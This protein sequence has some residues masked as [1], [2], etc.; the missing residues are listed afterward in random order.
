MIQR[1][2]FSQPS[3]PQD[4]TKVPHYSRVPCHAL[5]EGSGQ[6]EG[7]LL[8]EASQPREGSLLPTARGLRA[9]VRLSAPQGRSSARPV[10]QAGLWKRRVPAFP[11]SWLSEG[12]AQLEGSACYPDCTRVRFCGFLAARETRK[13][14][15]PARQRGLQ[16]KGELRGL[17]VYRAVRGCLPSKGSMKGEY[18]ECSAR[19]TRQCQC[20]ASK[21][22][23]QGE[24]LEG[25][26]QA[27]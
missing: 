23:L 9:R 22:S 13:G 18:S 7:S 2:A 1:P 20:R 10:G 27:T 6:H 16:A 24:G 4:H 14:R 15:V 11:Q 8:H 26:A 5:C 3:G 12:S 19:A 21:G 17:R 25:S